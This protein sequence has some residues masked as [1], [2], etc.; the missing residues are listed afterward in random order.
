MNVIVVGDTHLRAIAPI[1]RKDNYPYAILNK[2]EYISSLAK[3]YH[4]NT[5]LLLGDV[6]DSPVTSLPYLAAVINTF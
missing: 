3:A 4:S 2:L 1:S 5:L 6:F